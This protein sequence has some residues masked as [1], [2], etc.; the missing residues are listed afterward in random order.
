MLGGY[1]SVE[2]MQGFTPNFHNQ[3]TFCIQ[4]CQVTRFQFLFLRNENFFCKQNFI[5]AIYFL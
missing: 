5:Q 1:I 3:D 4:G 2:P